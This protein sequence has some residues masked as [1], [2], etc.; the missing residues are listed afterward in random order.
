[1][2]FQGHCLRIYLPENKQS[3]PYDKS[4]VAKPILNNIN[5]TFGRKPDKETFLLLLRRLAKVT[6]SAFP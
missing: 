4:R 5:E 2:E 6:R 1:M 3:M